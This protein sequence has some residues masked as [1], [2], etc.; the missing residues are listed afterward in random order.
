MGLSRRVGFVWVPERWVRLGSGE[1]GSSGRFREMG[2]SGVHVV[3]ERR[4]WIFFL[5]TGR[6]EFCVTERKWRILV[7]RK[8]EIRE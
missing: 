2:S 4:I 5:V 1:M 3:S 6:V 8:R 7:T